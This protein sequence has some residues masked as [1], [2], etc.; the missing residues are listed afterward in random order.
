MMSKHKMLADMVENNEAKPQTST[1]VL[2]RYCIG[3][4][5]LMRTFTLANSY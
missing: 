1:N 4:C 5:L 3:C 2:I